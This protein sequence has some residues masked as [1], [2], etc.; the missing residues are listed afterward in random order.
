MGLLSARNKLQ[1]V[2]DSTGRK[3]VSESTLIQTAQ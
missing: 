3:G 2:D 1:L